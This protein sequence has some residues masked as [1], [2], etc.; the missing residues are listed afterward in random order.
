MA[1]NWLE[2]VKKTMKLHPGKP[3]KEVL[4][5][6]KKTYSSAEKTVKKMV[7][8]GSSKKRVARKSKKAKKS[9]KRVSRRSRSSAR[10]TR[11]RSRK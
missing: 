7:G 10:K 3:F 8:K 1:N 4:K 11:R 9:A 2:H 5:M 6:A